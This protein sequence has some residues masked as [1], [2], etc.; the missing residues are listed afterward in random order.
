MFQVYCREKGNGPLLR[1]GGGSD[2]LQVAAEL[3]NA[4]LRERS[5]EMDRKVQEEGR[6]QAPVALES[7]RDAPLNLPDFWWFSKILVLVPAGHP[8]P[9]G[10]TQSE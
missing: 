2:P 8:D 5:H 4:V 1:I 9:L 7:T 10:I 6:P 3:G